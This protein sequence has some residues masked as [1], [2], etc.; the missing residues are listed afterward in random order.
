ME[1]WRKTNRTCLLCYW[2]F[3]WR[4]RTEVILMGSF[5]YVFK[6]GISHMPALTAASHH[7]E[8]VEFLCG[9]LWKVLL[10]T[11]FEFTD[12]Q[13]SRLNSSPSWR[14]GSFVLISSKVSR[15]R[16][17]VIMPSSWTLVSMMAPIGST[18]ILSPL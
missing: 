8:K 17:T 11:A 4:D 1:I 12:C 15:L 3:D 9:R 7:R 6:A 14:K 5:A 13:V 16:V 2:T 10:I 18:T